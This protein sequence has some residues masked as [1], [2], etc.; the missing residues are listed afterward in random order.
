MKIAKY[1]YYKSEIKNLVDRVYYDISEIMKE[2]G[3]LSFWS[4]DVVYIFC[5]SVSY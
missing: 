1:F 4:V 5:W 2:D 3:F